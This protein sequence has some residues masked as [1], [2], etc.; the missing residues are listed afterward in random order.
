[1]K[2]MNAMARLLALLLAAL[3][4]TGMLALAE[5]AETEAPEAEAVEAVE[6]EA[7][8]PTEEEEPAETEAPAEAED[9]SYGLIYSANNPIPDIA[10]RVRPAIVQV[11]TKVESWDADTRTADVYDAGSGSA[12][13]I[14]PLE[15][16]EGGY[17]L[18][19]YHVIQ[20]T[21][22][23]TAEWLDGTV[24][25]LELVGYDDGSDIAILKFEGPV[26][27]DAE[28]IPLGDSEA[29]RIGE[30]AIIIGNPG[31]DDVMFGS[32][33]AGIISGLERADPGLG[34]FSHH[35]TTIQIDAALTAGYSGGA[36]LNAKGEMVGIPVIY[37]LGEGMNFCIPISAVKGFIDQI[38]DSGNVV[39][40]RMG[41]TVV[42]IDGP[43]EAMRRFPPIG[44]QVYSVEKGTPADKAGLQEK[45]V[46]TEANGIRVKSSRDLVDAVDQCGEGEPM[47]LVVYRYEYDDDGNIKGGYEVLNL[48]LELEI[49]D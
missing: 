11:V 22:V 13:Y 36:L 41:V 10:E 46:I 30:L 2:Y 35:I 12:C 28:P 14:R 21:D 18:T 25:D 44:A 37:T 19:N 17:L 43:D 49:I 31:I 29:L 1:M 23:Y 4:L 15:N 8:E 47:K 48:E 39:R 40:P 6:G 3:M 38:I 33:S 26:P 9:N 7:E 16:G 5:P 20:D 34:N 42:T 45:D 32:V 24:S 27:G